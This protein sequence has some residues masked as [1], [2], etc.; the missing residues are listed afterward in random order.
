MH[1]ILLAFCFV[2]AVFACREA[3]KK[4]RVTFTEGR[5]FMLL[6]MVAYVSVYLVGMMISLFGE[7]DRCAERQAVR[8]AL[9]MGYDS[10]VIYVAEF[11]VGFFA[12]FVNIAIGLIVKK[13]AHPIAYSIALVTAILAFVGCGLYFVDGMLPIT[14]FFLSCCGLM[15]YYAVILGL[16]Y[17]EFCVLG[18]I[19]LQALICLFAAF[20]PLLLYVR[21]KVVGNVFWLVLA[22]LLCHSVLF[23]VV[24]SHYWMPLNRGFDLCFRE[25]NQLAACT[26]TTYIRVNIVI[27]VIGFLT[28]LLWNYCIYR[29]VDRK[30]SQ[31]IMEM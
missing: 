17:K 8:Q 14:G 18:N 21:K 11:A 6:A 22:N 7:H 30:E 1:W 28:D 10:S 26:G 5:L 9:D 12:G 4:M 19:Y 25:L 16:T 31:L 13:T 24:A 2:T 15:A 3:Y 20:A 27:F 23:I 29:L